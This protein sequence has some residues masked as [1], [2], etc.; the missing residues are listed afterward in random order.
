MRRRI[1]PYIIIVIISILAGTLISTWDSSRNVSACVHAPGCIEQSKQ[2]LG[3]LTTRNYGFPSV[4]RQYVTFEPINNNE[5][6]SNYAGYTSATTN[7]K[8]TSVVNI[9]VNIIFWAA[10]LYASYHLAMKLKSSR[11]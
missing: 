1:L 6:A 4:Y 10:L 8:S 9:I 3:T 7:T 5:K 2:P 11:T